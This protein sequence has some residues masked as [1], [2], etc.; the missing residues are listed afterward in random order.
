ME[1]NSND[2]NVWS[3]NPSAAVPFPSV[4]VFVCFLQRKDT[5]NWFCKQNEANV[6]YKRLNTAFYHTEPGILNFCPCLELLSFFTHLKENSQ[7]KPMVVLSDPDHC[8]IFKFLNN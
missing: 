3:R 4:S 5:F 7:I 6:S 8:I 1:W 2:E